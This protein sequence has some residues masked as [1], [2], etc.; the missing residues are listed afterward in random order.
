MHTRS[1]SFKIKDRSSIEIQAPVSI[2]DMDKL[3]ILSFG[4]C[5]TGKST[6][7][8]LMSRIYTGHFYGANEE[9]PLD[10]VAAKSGK[11]VTTKVK[12][13]KTGNLTLIDTPGTNDPDKKRTDI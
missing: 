2:E 11:S 13:V 6:F 3:T 10:F 8:S 1:H 5:G 9:K 12:V 4:E 7:L